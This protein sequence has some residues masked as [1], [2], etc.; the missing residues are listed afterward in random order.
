MIREEIGMGM[1]EELRALGANTA[2]ALQRFMGNSAL[3]EKMLKKLPKVV[4]DSPVLPLVRAR[5]YEAAT[6]N[7]HALK[8][9]T[10]NL[11]LD[12]LYEKYTLMVDLFRAG[13]NDEAAALLDE[14]L[15]I[16]KSFLD[17]IGKYI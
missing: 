8:G 2:E 7:A 14:T 1:I 11:S 12:P 10:G 5:D 15:I 13:K 17:V 3:Y 9:V 16:Q 4:E 6:S